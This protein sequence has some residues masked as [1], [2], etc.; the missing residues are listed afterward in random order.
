MRGKSSGLGISRREPSGH[1]SNPSLSPWI[2]DEFPRWSD[3]LTTHDVARLTRR[4]V[5]LI[6]ALALIGRF[7]RRARFHGRGIGW[8]RHDVHDWMALRSGCIAKSGQPR[9]CRANQRN[10]SS[11]ALTLGHD[12]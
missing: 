1:G 10:R 8:N 2:N 7:P 4:H 9:Q 11:C 5:W 6:S 3:L 12:K